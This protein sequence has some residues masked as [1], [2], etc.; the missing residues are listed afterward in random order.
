MKKIL[1]LIVLLAVVL[2][3]CS[4]EN[5]NDTITNEVEI[6]KFNVVIH[7]D[8][9]PNLLFSKYD[10]KLEVDGIE[11]GKMDHGESKDFELLLSAGEH[12]VSFVKDGSSSISGEEPL[13]VESDTEVTYQISCY[14]DKV[15]AIVQ[16]EIAPEVTPEVT[17]AV[18][19][20]P[21]P[22]VTPESTPEPTPEP[23]PTPKS[24]SYS[25]NDETTVRNGNSGVYSYVKDGSYQIYYIID[26]DNG[27]VYYFCHGNGNETC[28]RL[29]IDSG[30][31]NSVLII[32]YHDGDDVWSEGLHFKWKNQPEHLIMQ[33][34][35]GFEYDFYTTNLED[36][37][38]LRDTKT[39]HDY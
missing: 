15:E 37:L 22:E 36:A 6:E 2:S 8:F 7:V 16:A 13:Q 5:D 20:E 18:T 34:N 14:K 27:Y 9:V 23:T 3:A 11:Y 21:T 35:D 10:V 31:L 24:V 39:I 28:D 4:G 30:D 19:P 33:D 17:P 12:I 26:F 32:T 38:A 1:W 25:T 29:K